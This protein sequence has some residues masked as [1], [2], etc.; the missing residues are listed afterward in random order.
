MYTGSYVLSVLDGQTESGPTVRHYRIRNL[1]SGG[2]YI[3]GSRQFNKIPEL[4]EH[5]KSKNTFIQLQ[6][7]SPQCW[8]K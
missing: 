3:F 5:Y 6:Y 7:Y 4:V 2:C 8:W 1:D